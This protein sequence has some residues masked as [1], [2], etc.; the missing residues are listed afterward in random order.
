MVL[1]F[2][3]KCATIDW[4]AHEMKPPLGLLNTA[5]DVEMF[6]VAF[7]DHVASKL[8]AVSREG[9]NALVCTHQAVFGRLINFMTCLSNESWVRIVLEE[10][11]PVFG[12]LARVTT[13]AYG[14]P[15]SLFVCEHVLFE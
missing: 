4:N 15:H 10:G 14:K 13:V 6:Q 1:R 7:L 8:E 12:K 3:S 5:N 2:I 11:P 9:N